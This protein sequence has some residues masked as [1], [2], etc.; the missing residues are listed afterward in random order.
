[1]NQQSKITLA[2]TRNFGDLISDTF[3]YVRDYHKSLGKGLLYFVIPIIALAAILFGNYMQQV[4]AM[5][6]DP[7]SLDDIA[8]MFSSIGGAS[9]LG[10][11]ASAAMAAVVFNHMALVSESESGEV[12]VS[13]IWNRYKTDIWAI[14]GISI[15]T[16]II[17]FVGMIFFIIPGIFLLVKFS[18]I[19]AVYVKERVGISD[20]FS[21]SWHLTANYWWFTFGLT[22]V[23]GLLVSFMSYFLTVPI[24]LTSAF[25]GFA[26]GDVGSASTM[27][28]VIYSTAMLLGYIFYSL[29]YI[30]IGLHYFN[31]VERKEGSAMK[32]RIEQINA[33]TS[34]I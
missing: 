27:I 9:M 24:M 32:E 23:M 15:I 5:Q 21:R 18:L 12:T 6:A 1:M 29:L 2:R 28:T 11:F 33:G 14:I 13:G 4:M 31:L 34:G 25:V 20:A 7:N 10:M 17:A 30:S 19:P 8:S 22:I 16:G 26:G 3:T